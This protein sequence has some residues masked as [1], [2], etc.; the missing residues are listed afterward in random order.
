[1]HEEIEQVIRHL[2]KGKLA[3]CEEKHHVM[4]KRMY[5][6]GKMELTINE[7]VDNMDIEKAD[8]AL[9]QIN[10]TIGKIRC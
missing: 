6:K 9:S 7:V 8:T 1:M 2:L 5:A 10:A 4:F 3:L